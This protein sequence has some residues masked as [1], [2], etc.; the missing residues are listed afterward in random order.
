MDGGGGD[1]PQWGNGGSSFSVSSG[2]RPFP[3][4]RFVRRHARETS[5][6]IPPSRREYGSGRTFDHNATK[7]KDNFGDLHQKSSRLSNQLDSPG[8]P[9]GGSPHSVSA[10]DT[11]ESMLK[12][13]GEDGDSAKEL[14]RG[15]QDKISGDGV[16]NE[17]D[18]TEDQLVG[19]LQLEDE[20]D[21][22]SDK[23]KHHH[24]NDYRTDN[25]GQ[26]I[27]GQ[28]MRNLKR[29]TSCRSDIDR[30]NGSF[31][32]VFESLMPSKEEKVKQKQLLKVLEKLVSKE[33]PDARLYLYGSCANSFGFSKSDIDVCLTIENG[34]IDKREVLLKLADMLQLDNLQIV[35]A[36]IHARVP[37]VKLMDPVTGIS[38]DICVN[39]LLAVVNTKLLQDYAQIDVRLRQLAFIVKHWAKSRGVNE[40]YRGTLSSYALN[41]AGK[42]H[43]DT[44]FTV[45][46][47]QIFS[48]LHPDL[49][50]VSCM[51]LDDTMCSILFF[52]M[53]MRTT[54]FATLDNAECSYFDQ[55]E[56]LRNFGAQNGEGVAHLVW[57]FFHY[58]AYCHDYANDVIS[59]RTGE[60]LSKRAKNWTTRVG[61][62]RHLICIEDPC[63]VS[64]DLGRVVDK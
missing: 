27:L 2:N 55:V 57:A 41:Y 53:R 58:W 63:D 38:C 21:E 7:S 28:R 45:E 12:L 39:N 5:P 22:K 42:S 56:K 47:Q 43:I 8:P 11:E 51:V 13:R 32:E 36:L 48:H 26:W 40:T 52:L 16:R 35:Q 1:L 10:F 60:T 6:M 37:I 44:C 30:F 25:R 29:Q 64:H 24:D 20:V 3:T 23:K 17:L 33:W 9:P 46:H 49:S 59:I 14:R 61:N 62:D 50:L 31:V 4:P 15:G 54:Y 34:N 18:D 19:S